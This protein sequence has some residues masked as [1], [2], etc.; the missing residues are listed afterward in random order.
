GFVVAELL[1]FLCAFYLLILPCVLLGISFP[2]LLNLASEAG[3]VG[4]SVGGVYAANTLGTVLGSVLMGFLVLPALGSHAT[5][6]AA[7]TLNLLLGLSFALLLVPLS[8]ARRWVLGIV[9]ASL[10]VLVCGGSAQWDTRSLTRGTYVYFNTG[11]PIDRVL[12][13]AED[14]QGGLT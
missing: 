14:V 4:A 6:Q 10:V 2:L 1:R 12:Y 13:F 5:L 8:R 7:A 3:G 11:W 9:V